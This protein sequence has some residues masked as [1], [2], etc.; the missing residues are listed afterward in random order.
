V[1]QR[2]VAAGF[3]THFLQIAQA[4]VGL[5]PGRCGPSG[6][7]FQPDT[8]GAGLRLAECRTQTADRFWRVGSFGETTCQRTLACGQPEGVYG[9]S[10]LRTVCRWSISAGPVGRITGGG[11]R[12]RRMQAERGGE[13]LLALSCW[14]LAQ[15]DVGARE[16]RTGRGSRSAEWAEDTTGKTGYRFSVVGDLPQR[17]LDIMAMRRDRQC[18]PLIAECRRLFCARRSRGLTRIRNAWGADC[19]SKPRSVARYEQFPDHF[20]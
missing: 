8:P 17:V 5:A 4:W 20:G 11:A 9:P 13:K 7:G 10:R 1:S 12:A 19:S 3:F 6:L 15:P 16:C 14:L 2:D 18:R